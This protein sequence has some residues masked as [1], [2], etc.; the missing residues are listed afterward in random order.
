MKN[1][2]YNKKSVTA[3]DLLNAIKTMNNKE[4]NK[5]EDVNS[6]ERVETGETENDSSLDSL[7][8]EE[9]SVVR[10]K[11]IDKLQREPTQ[12]EI[13]NWLSEHTEGY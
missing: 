3:E 6:D 13:D 4:L 10:Q 1:K 11:L 9:Q 8:R 5:K 2:G 7:V 12:Q